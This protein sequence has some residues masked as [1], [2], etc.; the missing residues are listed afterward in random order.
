MCAS[1]CVTVWRWAFLCVA[2]SITCRCTCVGGSVCV[3]EWESVLCFFVHSPDLECQLGHTYPLL[4]L[5]SFPLPFFYF[6][7][8]P[9]TL[10]FHWAETHESHSPLKEK[11]RAISSLIL[12]Q[13]PHDKPCRHSTFLLFPC[14]L[15]RI[16]W[17]LVL[18][19][20]QMN[21]Q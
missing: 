11:V 4:L 20:D 17:L 7:I 12:L 21:I 15:S 3:R 9:C 13:S 2:L 5:A 19:K 14:S 8:L 16:L 1:L 10:F 18:S 6:N